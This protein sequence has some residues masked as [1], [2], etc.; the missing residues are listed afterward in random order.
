MVGRLPSAT[1][2]CIGLHSAP[3]FLTAFTYWNHYLSCASPCLGYGLLCRLN[4]SLSVVE[5][6]ALL[7][8]TYVFRTPPRTSPSTKMLS[9]CLLGHPSDT[10]SSPASSVA[11]QAHRLQV[12]RLET[13]AL[14]RQ[15]H[16]LL[17][18]ASSRTACVVRLGCIYYLCHPGLH[19]CPTQHGVPHDS[20]MG[21]G[22]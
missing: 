19:C 16:L 17:L 18:G 12:L 4:F 11:D 20:L 10:C 15:L 9:L 2:F 5:N 22:E 13:A 8:L 14:H 1:S 6:L 21:F 3:H 7:L